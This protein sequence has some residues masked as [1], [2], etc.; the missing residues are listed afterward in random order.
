MLVML[1][2]KLQHEQETIHMKNIEQS[3][4]E[5]SRPTKRRRI[6]D[7]DG[8]DCNRDAV[9]LSLCISLH[10]LWIHIDEDA[11]TQQRES[12]SKDPLSGWTSIEFQAL[13]AFVG[14]LPQS[15]IMLELLL[16]WKSIT[17]C[18][19]GKSDALERSQSPD[20]QSEDSG[21]TPEG[22]HERL[23]ESQIELA[24]PSQPRPLMLLNSGFTHE[25]PTL[26][27]SALLYKSTWNADRINIQAPVAGSHRNG[28]GDAELTG[29]SLT[30]TKTVIS[31]LNLADF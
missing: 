29:K 3:N 20:L 17:S 23:Q 5:S 7:D 10:R 6:E 16:A 2:R 24:N 25:P 18:Y 21:A 28:Q 26:S 12:L 30:L 11:A 31:Q 1:S 22:N 4:R 13:N 27:A 19:R 14:V 9:F 8:G 15:S